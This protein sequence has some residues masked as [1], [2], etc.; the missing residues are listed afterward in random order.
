MLLLIWLFESLLASGITSYFIGIDGWGQCWIPILLLLGYFIF[1]GIFHFIFAFFFGILTVNKNKEYN[2]VSKFHAWMFDV[3]VAFLF[4]IGRAKIHVFGKEKLPDEPALYVYNHRSKFDSICLCVKIR[5]RRLI[6]I[7]KPENKNIPIAGDFLHRCCYLTIDRE[8]ARNAMRTINRASN[9]I[10][11]NKYNVAVAPEGTRNKTDEPLLPFRE[12]CLKIALKAECPI[13]ICKM[14][15][16]ENISK[17]FPFKKTHV[18]LY[19]LDVLKYE[20]IKDLST[21]EISEIV[22]NKMLEHTNN[23]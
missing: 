14:Y 2:K 12:G 20:N 11:E 17:N 4:Q 1:F 15:N 21:I 8:N 19:I 16:M 6:H 18:Y 7:S 3:T 9:F 22:R 10:V 23:Q 5:H 13:I